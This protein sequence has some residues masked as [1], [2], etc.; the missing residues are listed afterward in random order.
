[1]IKKYIVHEG[2]GNCIEYLSEKGV[3]EYFVILRVDNL[4][5]EESL[6]ILHKQYSELFEICV[7]R[8]SIPVYTR[9]FLSD[10]E[11]QSSFVTKSEIYKMLSAGGIRIIGNEPVDSGKVAIV[12]YLIKKE[13]HINISK[14]ETE[15]YNRL[16]LKGNS[17]SM[18]FI[19]DCGDSKDRSVGMQSKSIFSTIKENFPDID[20]KN[21]LVRTWIS[22]RDI[23][24]NYMPFVKERNNF[25]DEVSM[26]Y[27]FPSSTAVE[28]RSSDPHKLVS[29]D[30]I[31]I[32]NIDKAQ[33]SKMEAHD[34]M[35]PTL[36]YGV[37]F[38]RGLKV[39]FGDRAHYHLSGTASIDHNGDILY[40]DDVKLQVERAL[41]NVNALLVNSNINWSNVIYLLFYIRDTKDYEE[42]QS[43]VDGILPDDIPRLYIKSS[44]C[45]PGWLVEVDG[46]AIGSGDR[47]FP[48]FI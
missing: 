41:T 39:C 45:R 6:S 17:Y 33:M 37:S 7:L 26:R 16:C 19:C 14:I 24:N 20:F 1:M 21:E 35:P 29:I 3:N 34:F 2:K 25:F 48:D 12:S 28:G 31:S 40:P 44:I 8:E 30:M 23:D 47:Q 32:S 46:I 5:I 11:N 36:K 13:N 10:V 18:Q 15:L 9:I 42:I 4:P 38:E 43:V 22:I 27:F